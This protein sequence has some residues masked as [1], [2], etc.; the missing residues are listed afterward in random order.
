MSDT[1]AYVIKAAIA[2][3]KASASVATLVAGRI[4]TDVPQNTAFPYVVLS[5]QSQPFA[6][7]DFSGQ[8]HA[9][10][11]QVFSR[12]AG[13]SECLLVRAACLN[14]LDRNEQALA[15]DFGSVVRCEYSGF[16]DAF[17]E[18]DGRTWQAIG[19]LEVVVV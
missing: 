18:D 13:V 15:L 12:F 1:A 5:I 6:A 8:T 3:L 7:D 14:A 10:R 4:Y 11:I 17:R 9:L 16:S 2:A 19:E